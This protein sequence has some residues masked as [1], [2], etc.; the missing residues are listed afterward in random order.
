[1]ALAERSKEDIARFKANT[2]PYTSAMAAWDAVPL[3]DSDKLEKMM[4]KAA[5]IDVNRV[6]AT[7]KN[8]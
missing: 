5:K 3:L 2:A 6:A 4:K 8:R 1:M 7:R